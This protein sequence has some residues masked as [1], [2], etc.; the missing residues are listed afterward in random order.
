[1]MAKVDLGEMTPD[2]GS[3]EIS[4]PASENKKKIKTFPTVY[5][6]NPEELGIT[7]EMVGEKIHLEF[8]C[9]I[10]SVELTKRANMNDKK[11]EKQER[12]ECQL[13]LMQAYTEADEEAE[14]GDEDETGDDIQDDLTKGIKDAQEK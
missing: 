5:I 4:S 3:P 12:N 6:K 2:Y 10:K 11:G 7:P 14:E 1:M 9:R 8:D 13:E